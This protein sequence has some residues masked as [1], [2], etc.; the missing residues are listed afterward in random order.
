MAAALTPA[1]T[2]IVA[3]RVG[4]RLDLAREVGA[5][6]TV[7]VTDQDLVQAVREITAGGVDGVVETTGNTAV[8]RQ[9]ADLL[10]VRG[11]LV[12]VGAPAFGSEVALDVNAMLPGR[13]VVGLTLGDSETQALMPA[14]VELVRT[15]RMPIHKLIREY[16][17]A[18]IQQAVADVASGTTIKPILRF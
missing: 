4:A 12:I 16:P 7:D 9:G 3:D 17:F 10:A 15:G 1:T 6:H 11:T 2:V 5:T 18:D 8:L 13:H 14:L